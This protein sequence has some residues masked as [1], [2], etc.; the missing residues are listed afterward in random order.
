MSTRSNHKIKTKTSF[1]EEARRKQILNIALDEIQNKGFQNTTIQEIAN[2][3]NVSKGVIYYHFNGRADLLNNIWSALIAELFEYRK[4]RVE[5]QRSAGAKLRVYVEA[6]F[7]F[8]KK[9]LNKFTALFRMGIDLGSAEAK[10]NP[11]ST[12]ANRRCFAFLSSI[13]KEG[14]KNG[15]FRDFS[16]KIIAPI[17][18]AAIDGLCLQWVS[19]PELYDLGAC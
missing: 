6:N 1:I 18:Q 7:E 9:N 16:P 11:W 19:T 14:Q 15:E 8:L 17:V 5:T 2:K 4:E 12:E 13:L 3:A 10:P